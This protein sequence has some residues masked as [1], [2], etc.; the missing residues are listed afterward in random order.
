M[1]GVLAGVCFGSQMHFIELMLRRKSLTHSVRQLFRYQLFFGL[2][3]G[4]V[5]MSNKSQWKAL[6]DEFY[7]QILD[8]RIHYLDQLTGPELEDH[9]DELKELY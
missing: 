5:L 6:A 8:D 1:D 4:I 2:I 3:W 7:E 9:R